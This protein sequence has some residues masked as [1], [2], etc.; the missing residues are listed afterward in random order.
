[1]NDKSSWNVK[2]LYSKNVAAIKLLQEKCK[3]YFRHLDAGRA[4]SYYSRLSELPSPKSKTRVMWSLMKLLT[5]F[6]NVDE[7]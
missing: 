6:G 1:M 2:P 4:D 3:L 5:L 7:V